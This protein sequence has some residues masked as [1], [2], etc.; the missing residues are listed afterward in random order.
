VYVVRGVNKGWKMSDEKVI[1]GADSGNG[2]GI[3][4]WKR[5]TDPLYGPLLM[6][7]E[8][9]RSI[10]SRIHLTFTNEQNT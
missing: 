7:R 8:Y 2:Y 6:V 4:I 10:A 1:K 3:D 5:R 9:R